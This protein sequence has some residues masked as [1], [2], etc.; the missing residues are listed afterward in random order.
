MVITHKYLFVYLI[1]ASL[2]VKM[3]LWGYPIHGINRAKLSLHYAPCLKGI[4]L[5]LNKD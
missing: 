4:G 1:I 2:T 3:T 5:E